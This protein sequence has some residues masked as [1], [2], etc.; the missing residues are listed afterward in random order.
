LAAK[1]KTEKLSTLT[2]TKTKTDNADTDTHGRMETEDMPDVATIGSTVVINVQDVI[3]GVGT[4]HG[5]ANIGGGNAGPL[6]ARSAEN[7]EQT[8][9]DNPSSILGVSDGDFYGVPPKTD[10]EGEDEC[11]TTSDDSGDN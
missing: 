1:E 5:S 4:G 6:S 8:V 9:D 11:I 2:P 10:E 7:Q 3:L